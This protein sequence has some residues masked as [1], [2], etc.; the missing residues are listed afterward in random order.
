MEVSQLF[1]K[2]KSNAFNVSIIL[3]AFLISY[4]TYKKQNSQIAMLLETKAT[5]AKKSVILEEIGGLEK[6]IDLYK[7]FLNY[8]DEGAVINL[9]NEIAGNMGIK[10]VSIKPAAQEADYDYLIKHPFALTVETKDSHA[11]GK[12]LSRIENHS[13]FYLV[14]AL[15]ILSGQDEEKL[16]VNLSLSY[17]VFKK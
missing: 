9:I 15:N 17:V 16:T 3:F 8:R 5:E 7:N 12:F 13:D 11:L 2:L 4:N 10:I 1:T 14:D 6:R